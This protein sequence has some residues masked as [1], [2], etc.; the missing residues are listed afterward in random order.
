MVSK[1]RTTDELSINSEVEHVESSL[2]DLAAE[3]IESYVGFTTV[4]DGEYTLRLRDLKVRYTKKGRP[5]LQAS[6]DVAVDDPDLNPSIVN[7]F[8]NLPYQGCPSNTRRMFNDRLASFRL[9]FDIPAEE[10][11]E[12]IQLA[13]SSFED[14]DEVIYITDFNGSMGSALLVTEPSSEYGDRNII[15]SFIF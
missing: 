1:K 11:V 5:A 3:E 14:G 13:F 2:L 12:A 6:F 8:I 7:E 9:S 15:K 4:P 10:M